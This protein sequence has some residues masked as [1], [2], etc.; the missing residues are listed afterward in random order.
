MYWEKMACNFQIALQAMNP[1]PLIVYSFLDEEDWDFVLKLDIRPLEDAEP[2]SRH[3]KMRRRLNSWC[4]GLLELPLENCKDQKVHFLHRTVRDFLRTKDMQKRLADYINID[5]NPNMSLCR[6]YLAQIKTIQPLP[7]RIAWVKERLDDVFHHAFLVQK[8][9]CTSDVEMFDELDRTIY[10]LPTQ[11]IA[12]YQWW[13]HQGSTIMD[14]AIRDGLNIYVAQ[15]LDDCHGLTYPLDGRQQPLLHCALNSSVTADFGVNTKI[16]R[17]LLDRGADPNAKYD[18]STLWALFLSEVCDRWEV[19]ANGGLR[20]HLH[21]LL[22]LLLQYGADPKQKIG[23]DAVWGRYL[24]AAY[25]D[26]SSE[27]LN[28]SRIKM[29]QLLLQYGV[30]PNERYQNSTVW[31]EFVYL[32]SRKPRRGTDF[33]FDVVKLLLFHTANPGL[34]LISAAGD[35]Q[36]SCGRCFLTSS[37]Q[38]KLLNSVSLLTP[39]KIFENISNRFVETVAICFGGSLVIVKHGWGWVD[40]FLL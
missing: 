6:A 8:E 19:R 10:V 4:Q 33:D 23:P 34:R 20:R 37:R 18:G 39:M 13:D 26:Q 15:K 28:Q 16:V 21:H 14:R 9:L 35:R 32:T 11:D 29:I 5:F 22:G 3:K 17:L 2:Q 12:S 24:F 7:V 31:M 38:S 40:L 30:D 25:E 1:L 36:Q 27:V